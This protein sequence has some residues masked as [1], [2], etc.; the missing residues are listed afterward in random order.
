M[1]E[2]AEAGARVLNT[3]AVQYAKR[4]GITIRSVS[5]FAA[6]SGTVVG[7]FYEEARTGL[8]RAVVFEREIVYVVSD[9]LFSR[10]EI[11]GIL[12]F[13]DDEAAD[14]KQFDLKTYGG[15]GLSVYLH[16]LA[17]K[18]PCLPGH[19][20]AAG[21]PLSEADHLLRGVGRAFAGRR[22]DQ[23]HRPKCQ[24]DPL[25]VER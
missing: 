19:E 25:S 17:G 1:Q 7:D 9:D 6:G 23:R 20:T 3:A 10:E 8:V 24:E 14:Y 22:G 12:D 21:L 4:A 5:T 2:M 18:R 11:T 16:P 15:G 13:L